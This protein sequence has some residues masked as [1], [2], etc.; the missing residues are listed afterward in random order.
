MILLLLA[1]AGIFESY[2]LINSNI[3]CLKCGQIID[4]EFIDLS[5]YKPNLAQDT[6]QKDTLSQIL[7]LEEFLIV[8]QATQL[9]R[10]ESNSINLIKQEFI[11]ENR[12]GSLMKSLERIPGVS[13][14]GIGA[15]A[16]KPLIRG[17]GFN[18]VLVVENGVKH[19]GQQWGADHGLEVDQF[20]ADQVI[21]IKGPVSFKYGSD[22]IA[23]VVDIREKL[24]PSEDGFGGSVDLGVRSNNAWLGGSV[25]LFA[26]KNNWF[27]DGRLTYASY[28]DFKV[29]SDSV[30]VYDFGVALHNNQVR[31][32]AGNEL[33]F[34]GRVGFI[35][36]KLRNTFSVS[37]V[38][39]KSGFFANAHGL[40][41][42]Q[43]DAGLHDRSSR[44]FLLP[45]QEVHHLK[46][47]NKLTYIAGINFLEVDLGYQRNDRKEWSQYVNHGYMP[48]VYPSEMA[49][50]SSLERAFD[51]EVFSGSIKDDLFFDQH[52]VSFGASVESQR[53]TIGGWGFLIPAFQQFSYGLYAIEKYKLNDRWLFT[54]AIRY[55][56]SK[57]QVEAYQDW[58]QSIKGPEHGTDADYLYRAEDFNREINS[59]VWSVGFNFVPGDLSFKGNLGTSFRIPIAKELA[60]NGVNYH[61]FRYEKGNA[62]L[63]PERSFQLDLGTELSKDR[64]KMSFS[65]FLNYFPNYIYLNPSFEHDFLYG[66]GNQVF[67][68]TQSEVFR[69]GAELSIIHQLTQTISME[70]LSEYVYSRQLSGD[71][72]GYS[73][74]FSPPP[75]VLLNATYKPSTTGFFKSPYLALDYRLTARQETI[76]PPEKI[77]AGFQLVNLRLGSELLLFNRNIQTDI[78]VQNVFNT[79]Y[80]SHTSFYRLIDLPEA[81]RNLTLSMRYQF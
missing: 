33:N 14:I 36:K 63:S 66:A 73:L 13:T 70:L 42:R 28:G 15:G 40:E 25:H 50:P 80:L 72:K 18:Q 12:G 51:K 7:D 5:H 3:A 78:Q 71:K 76:V 39:T 79:R 4:F 77:T 64:W 58:F 20:A 45:Y 27:A 57:I 26:R 74:P 56:H 17:L 61:Y 75:S 30:F 22:A 43:V 81:G 68:Y 59:V 23:G 48:P 49:F 1:F 60:A 65:P 8:D 67:N 52:T 55:D 24:V 2:L 69:Y 11:R 44:D 21:I 35:G 46:L 16:S 10:E 37:R 38:S 29:P 34:S 32:T 19:E 54:G 41:P 6:I 9:R 31:N 62:D 47:I 53:N